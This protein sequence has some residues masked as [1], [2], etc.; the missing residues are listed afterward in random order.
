MVTQQVD[1]WL[2]ATFFTFSGRLTIR[3]MA[4]IK[5]SGRNP[6]I[7]RL[8]MGEARASRMRSMSSGAPP[9]T[10]TPVSWKRQEST[11]NSHC[12]P[13]ARAN[14]WTSPAWCG[15]SDV[16]IGSEGHNLGLPSFTAVLHALIMTFKSYWCAMGNMWKAV[17]TLSV[18][19]GG[20]IPRSVEG[21]LIKS[22]LE[23]LK[24]V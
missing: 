7:M 15:T 5:V 16:A 21:G 17:W 6:S 9:E 12:L 10:V 11:I 22:F 24:H 20:P 18:E 1:I 2:I 4:L 14:H 23:L 3:R 19:G 13:S 8:S